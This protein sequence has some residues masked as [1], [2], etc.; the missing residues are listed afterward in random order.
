MSLGAEHVYG[1]ALW[2]AILWECGICFA[3][4]VIQRRHHMHEFGDEASVDVV[5]EKAQAH[6]LLGKQKRGA[7][8]RHWVLIC[9][10]KPG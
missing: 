3:K 10:H 4:Q 8:H 6:S 7:E 5:G 9:F 2:W 1:F